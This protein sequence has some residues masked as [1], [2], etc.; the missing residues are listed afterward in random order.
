[1]GVGV[2]VLMH[3]LVKSQNGLKSPEMKKKIFVPF[4]SVPQNIITGGGY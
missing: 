2:N 1:M 3:F 4:R